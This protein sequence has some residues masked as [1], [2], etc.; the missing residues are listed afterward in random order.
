MTKV[1]EFTSQTWS[2]LGTTDWK[3]I[4]VTSRPIVAY[5]SLGLGLVTLF[6][7]GHFFSCIYVLCVGAVIGI[8]EV[9]F[10]Y[11][12]LPQLESV[13]TQLMTSGLDTDGARGV[14]YI[15]AS[16]GFF[17]NGF[18]PLYLG[19]LVILGSGI[20]HI[21]AIFVTPESSGYEAV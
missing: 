19:G 21:L 8:M 20:S 7:F 10:I 4:S 1:K 5:S 3:V 16:F 11:S 18:T 2:K 17:T 14:C 15:L 6:L 13:R 9:E 12:A